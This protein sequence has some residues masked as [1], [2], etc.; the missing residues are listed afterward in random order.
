MPRCW[1]HAGLRR[2]LAA[3]LFMLQGSGFRVQ[4]S[5]FRVQGSGFRVQGL[6]ANLVPTP[7]TLSDEIL[8]LS[9]P[10]ALSHSNRICVKHRNALLLLNPIPYSLHP[11]L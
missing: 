5:G 11:T 10:S 3:S 4:G 9:P 2:L 6:A 8:A 1:E 7:N